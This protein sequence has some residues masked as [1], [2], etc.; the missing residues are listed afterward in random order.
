MLPI[1]VLLL[2]V[3]A[4]MTATSGTK[5]MGLG[6]VGCFMVLVGW[7]MAREG[8]RAALLRMTG[9]RGQARVIKAETIR[10]RKDG[11]SRTRFELEV[12]LPGKDRYLAETRLWANTMDAQRLAQSQAVECASIRTTRAAC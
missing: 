12:E 3:S 1:G 8:K 11:T 9:L 6:F 4:V 5:G 2:L 7:L 10:T